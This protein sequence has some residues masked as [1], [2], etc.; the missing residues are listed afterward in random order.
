MMRILDWL[1]TNLTRTMLKRWMIIGFALLL[2]G[3]FSLFSF[4]Q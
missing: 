2:F 1:A 4:Y 3:L